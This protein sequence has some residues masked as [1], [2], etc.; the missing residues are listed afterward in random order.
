[1]PSKFLPLI[2]LCRLNAPTGYLLSFFP[3]GYGLLLS[4][5]AITQIKILIPLLFIGSIIARSAGCIIND[6]LDRDFD[7]KVART[8]NRPL[9]NHTV[10]T[11]D[12]LILLFTLLLSALFILLTLTK[13]A[14]Y[15]G[16]IAFVMIVIYPLMK[17]ITNLPQIFLGL[18]F[19]IG[20]LIG[21]ASA[22][23][24]LSFQAFIMYTACCFWTI[25]YDTIYGFMDIN[26][27]KKIGVK[28]MAILLEK[29]NYKLWL[30]VFYLLFIILFMLA[31]C[32]IT[33][34]RFILFIGVLLALLI[35]IWQVKTLDI[36]NQENCLI[37]FKVNNY[38]G[39]ILL[40]T[41]YL[42]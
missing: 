8:K 4:N 25:G 5:P 10:T 32:V 21:Y 9:A 24:S 26:D 3:A 31:S 22:S 29:R 15:T 42:C 11:K 38:V 19:N 7:T 35:L 41:I 34:M 23:D 39:A 14:I 2:R 1:M 37:R 40:L 12:A 13:T 17:R 18:T 16:F 28:S 20:S 36:T 30:Y 27:D 6:I 33:N